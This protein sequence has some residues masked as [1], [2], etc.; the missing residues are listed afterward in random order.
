MAY[1]KVEFFMLKRDQ[2]IGLGLIVL[3]VI[4]GIMTSRFPVAFTPEYPG[5]K[6]VPGLAV[7]GLIVCGL[8]IFIESTRKQGEEKAFFGKEGWKKVIISF[9][10]LILYI[11]GMKYLGYMISTPILLYVVATM[12]AKG[13]T[14]RV[15]A[16]I[17]YSI[18]LTVLVYLVYVQLFG[19]ALPRGV[20]F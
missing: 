17:L 13:Q 7:I 4:F 1:A 16:K 14:A 18:I 15:W 6:A 20:I 19:L 11:L 10:V 12:F 2:I 5:P 9:V 3:G 8:G